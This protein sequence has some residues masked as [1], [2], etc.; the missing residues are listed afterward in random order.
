MFRSAWQFDTEALDL[1]DQ[2][3]RSSPKLMERALKRQQT[4]LK[5]RVLKIVRVEPPPP[6]PG[7]TRLMTPRQRRA[8]W[9]TN[10]FGHGIPYVRT[11]RLVN[12]WEAQFEFTEDGGAF[13]VENTSPAARFVIGADQQAFHAATGWIYAP[14]VVDDFVPIVLTAYEETWRTI[15]DPF[16]G[17][18]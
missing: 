11:H 14:R 4:R 2:R 12:S 13:V 3:V 16:A 7:I 10:G 15:S 5:S 8:F 9:A 1:A 18:K 6:K 17:V